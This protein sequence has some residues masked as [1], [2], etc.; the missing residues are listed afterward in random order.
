V[1]GIE[2]RF[3]ELCFFEILASDNRSVEDALTAHNESVHS[4]A[5]D[6]GNSSS[7]STKAP[8]SSFISEILQAA[9]SQVCPGQ[10][11]CTGHGT[12]SNSTCICDTGKPPFSGLLRSK[13]R[14]F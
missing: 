5:D 13:K 10:P 3:T 14:L 1:T 2:Q 7:S 6:Q 9:S 4:A 12:C 11:S 8:Y